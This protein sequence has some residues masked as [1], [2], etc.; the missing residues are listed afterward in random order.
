MFRAMG[1]ALAEGAFMFGV[2]MLIIFM[3]YEPADNHIPADIRMMM[4]QQK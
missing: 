1:Y 4:E 2:L 3:L